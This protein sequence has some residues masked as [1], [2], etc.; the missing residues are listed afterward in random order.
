MISN[1]T[2]IHSKLREGT[3]HLHGVLEAR[4]SVLLSDTL[5]LGE[6]VDIEK[7]LLGFYRPVESQLL[8]ISGWDDAPLNLQE[9]QKIPFLI[10]DLLYLDIDLNGIAAIPSCENLPTLQTVPQALGCLYVLEGSTLGG[11]IITRHLNKSLHLDE[12]RGCSFFNSY[13]KEVGPMWRGFLNALSQYTQKHGGE[14]VV[15]NSAC[16]TFEAMD[17]WLAAPLPQLEYAD[18]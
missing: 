15:V 17:Q 1:P 4:L 3:K 11:T 9:R 8:S 7:K 18:V 6:Y 10:E 13:G 5:A 12:R 2:N 16:Q 14:D